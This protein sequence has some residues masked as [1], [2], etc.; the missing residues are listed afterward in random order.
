M[1]LRNYDFVNIGSDIKTESGGGGIHPYHEML[2]ISSGSILLKW[3]GKEYAVNAPALFLL[4]PNTP[5]FLFK[6]SAS[7]SFMYLELDMQN[8][9]EFPALAQTLTWNGLQ[10]SDDRH[11]P[12]LSQVYSSALS[13]LEILSPQYPFKEAAEQI[14]TLEVRK[15]LLLVGC[16]LQARSSQRLTDSRQLP[17]QAEARERIQALIRHMESNHAEHVTVNMLA[18][19]AHLDVSYFIRLFRSVAGKTPL[20]YLHELRMNAAA[21]YLS[22]TNMP[23][24]DIAAATGFQSVHYFSRQFKQTSGVTP[25][26]WRQREQS[27]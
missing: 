15:I 8:S 12:E 19:Y 16:C 6:Q 21:C 26:Q 20:Q 17:E 3:M 4:S 22:T 23:V 9:A 5:H 27:S 18:A 14:A 7:C 1:Y 25:T 13:L 10:S 2:I 11:A 24:Q